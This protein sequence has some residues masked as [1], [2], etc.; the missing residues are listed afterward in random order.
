MRSSALPIVLAFLLL[1]S[2]GPIAAVAGAQSGGPTPLDSDD[3]ASVGGGPTEPGDSAAAV[4]S[5]PRQIADLDVRSRTVFEIDLQSDRDARWT[6]T[7]R[8]VL[9][10]DNETAAFERIAG[11]FGSGDVGPSADLYRN[12]AA[13]ASAAAGREMSIDDVDR[14]TALDRGVDLDDVDGIDSLEGLEDGET[15]AVGELRL[16]FTWTAFLRADGDQLVLDDAF[17]TADGGTWL[18]SLDA[19][20]RMVIHP[21]DGYQADSFPGIGLSLSDRAVV[22]D[23]PRTFGPDDHIEVVYSPAPGAISGPPWLL[24]AG[25]IVLAAMVIAIGLVRYRR[26]EVSAPES[27]A[28]TD[29]ST[30]SESGETESGMAVEST[31]PTG[32]AADVEDA[33]APDTAPGADSTDV[34]LESGAGDGTAAGSDETVDEPDES[35][36]EPDEPED[37][38]GT[39]ETGAA[40]TADGT[41]TA[42][43]ADEADDE[44]AGDEGAATAPDPSLL[45]DE[46]RVEALL[47]RNGGRMRQADIVSE[48]GWSDAKVSQLLSAMADEERVEKLR[49]GREN[50]ISLPDHTPEDVEE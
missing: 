40:E 18:P 49:L 11:R 34:S 29:Q 2:G 3:V 9:T 15:V 7:V 16:T 42:D 13:G 23:G 12:L 19:T 48:T 45:S 26:H 33:E 37:T 1:L 28:G 38:D 36:D 43:E 25:A 50:L 47:E 32:G 31:E 8:Y 22:I 5:R 41:E 39:T 44:K 27:T 6:V 21:P 35:V 30:A 46:E 24:L 4:G 10:D 20:Q 17:R 14:E